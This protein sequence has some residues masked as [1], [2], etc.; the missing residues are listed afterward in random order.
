[1]RTEGTVLWY[2][3]DFGDDWQHRIEVGTRVLGLD[4]GDLH[5]EHP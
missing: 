3:Y 2:V 1:L 4:Q 5:Y